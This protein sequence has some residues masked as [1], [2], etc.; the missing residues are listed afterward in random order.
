M[1]LFILVFLGPFGLNYNRIVWPWNFAMIIYLYLIFLKFEQVPFSFRT[2]FTS[3]NNLVF[4]FLGILPALNFAGWWDNYLSSGVYSGK[5][6][7]MIICVK[8][9]SKCRELKRFCKTG[10]HQFCDGSNAINL[11]YWSMAET[12]M[13]PYPEIRAYEILQHKLE[14]KYPAAG[15]TF[16]YINPGQ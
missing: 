2:V 15:L 4:V 12:Q 7:Q 10:T 5:L 8:D 13:A 9:T 14:A 16:V 3:W 1:H 6:P 11:Q